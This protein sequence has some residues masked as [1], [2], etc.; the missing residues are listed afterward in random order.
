LLVI[1]RAELSVTMK[2]GGEP[3]LQ[4]RMGAEHLVTLKWV[5]SPS[6]H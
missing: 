3:P 1:I 2:K 6:C 5:R 4:V